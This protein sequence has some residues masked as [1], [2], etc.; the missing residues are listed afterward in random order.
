MRCLA[1]V[2]A[3]GLL[4]GPAI[5]QDT[6]TLLAARRAAQALAQAAVALQEA[7]AARDRV[8][9]LTRTVRAYEDG[10]A[11]LREGLRRVKIREQSIRLAFEAK[12]AEV[13]RL[14]GV[15]A[16]LERNPEPVTL[17]HPG[18]PLETAR[19]GM[20]LAEMTPALQAEAEALGAQLEELS[21]LRSLQEGAAATLADGLAGVQEARLRL[22]QA[23]AEREPLPRRTADDP[24]ALAAILAGADTLESFAAGLTAVPLAGSDPDVPPFR[25]SRGRL[26]LPVEGR[27][28][29]GFEVADAAGVARPGLLLA[30]RPQALVTAPAAA[31]VRYAGPLLDYGNVIVLEPG[32]GYLLVLAGLGQIFAAAN[33]VVPAGAALGL[34]GGASPSGAE[35]ASDAQEAGGAE[36][37]ETLYMELREGG[38]PVDPAAWF[39]PQRG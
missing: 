13:E 15:L 25:D 36:R 28:L 4:A 14:T 31:T 34:M 30:T 37:P 12:R 7:D 2:L 24:E 16:G 33:E 8:D 19:A 10:L 32:A 5:A 39:A 3:M 9:A 11:A 18:G 20:L 23:I 38:T 27:V 35:F 21:L 22:S 29:R 6:E 1:V 17:L 26:P